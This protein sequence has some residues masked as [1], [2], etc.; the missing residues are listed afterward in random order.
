MICIKIINSHSTVA[1]SCC[2]RIF[3]TAEAGAA[4]VSGETTPAAI[5][6]GQCRYNGHNGQKSDPEHGS[7]W[8]VAVRQGA[9]RCLQPPFSWTF[10][11]HLVRISQSAGTKGLQ[12]GEMA[13]E[14]EDF[15]LFVSFV[16]FVWQ[17]QTPPNPL[18]A[19]DSCPVCGSP[20]AAGGV[21]RSLLPPAAPA[22]L[23]ISFSFSAHPP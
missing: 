4:V 8:P 21:K 7:H 18:L 5:I 19:V 3:T 2:K 20:C 23:L 13:F 11:N 12:R 10:L 17:P 6:Y 9:S 1:L 14:C 22:I 16:S 15:G